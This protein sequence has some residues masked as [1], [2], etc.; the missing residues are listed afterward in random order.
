M[1][2]THVSIAV[3]ALV[4][5]VSATA[6]AQ[7]PP[8]TQPQFLNIFREQLKPARGAEHAQWEAGWPAAAEKAK[9]PY[10]YLALASMTGPQEV[11]YVFSY[12][13][14]AAFGHAT[15]WEEAQPGLTAEY[16][17]LAKT[18]SEFLSEATA[19]QAVAVPELSH[20]AFPDIGKMRF[21]EISTFRIRPGH[22][23]EWVAATMAYKAAA[24]RSAPNASWRTYRVV[25]GAP[26]GTFLIFSS[27]ASFGDF[28]KMM[29]EGEATM[30]GMTAEEG[31]TLGKFMKESVISM[32]SNRYRLDPKQS[33][34]DAATK[35]KDLAFWTPKKP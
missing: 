24:A 23:A 30:K 26:E 17:R 10:S 6:F 5:S 35:L 25:A 21:W 14:Q 19:L 31:A 20:G 1:R 13:S 33:Y 12:P 27:V 29:A 32:A 7:A 8:T 18:D 4:A 9:S 15:A 2:K 28:D 34:V 22:D 3:L 16:D 11:W